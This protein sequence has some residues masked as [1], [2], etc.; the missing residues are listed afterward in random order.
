MCLPHPVALSNKVTL[1]DISGT[2]PLPFSSGWSSLYIYIYKQM[3]YL[4]L[5]NINS[6]GQDQTQ[7]ILNIVPWLKKKRNNIYV[8]ITINQMPEGGSTSNSWNAMYTKHMSDSGK[9]PTSFYDSTKH[10]KVCMSSWQISKTIIS[11]KWQEMTNVEMTRY[12]YH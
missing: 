7:N 2:D 3:Y 9:C 10:V 6:N 8:S 4:F 11:A 1:C 12:A 5:P